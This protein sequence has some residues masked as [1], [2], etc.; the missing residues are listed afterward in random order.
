MIGAARTQASGSRL[1]SG[2]PA[3]PRPAA[4]RAS[5]P[6]FGIRDA[7]RVAPSPAKAAMCP[8]GAVVAAANGASTKRE[9]RP[10]HIA[11]PRLP[12]APEAVLRSPVARH[13]HL[14]RAW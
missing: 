7:L 13:A 8:R 9:P 4:P 14:A 10:P 2:A 1:L 12:G 5:K 3:T 6:F 11:A